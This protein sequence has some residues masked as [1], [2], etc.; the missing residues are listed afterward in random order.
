M[1]W[2][3][4]KPS[5]LISPLKVTFGSVVENGR[6]NLSRSHVRVKYQHEPDARF[7]PL[8]T[9]IQRCHEVMRGGRPLDIEHLIV[10]P[11][12]K[13]RYAEF[14]DRLTDWGP[15]VRRAQEAPLGMK[16]DRPPIPTS[17]SQYR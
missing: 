8:A 16:R 17:R 9:F 11:I 13:Q 10:A 7:V 12:V 2:K 4:D 1:F 3:N 5:W 6:R 15:A 14:F